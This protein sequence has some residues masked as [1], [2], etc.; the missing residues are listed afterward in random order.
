M[1]NR[2]K[3]NGLYLEEYKPFDNK[4]AKIDAWY[5][6]HERDWV[7]EKLN[8]EDFQVGD[9]IRVYDKKTKDIIVKELREKFGV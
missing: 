9:V 1:E 3:I 7:I 8:A 5:D 4:V 2:I 6:R